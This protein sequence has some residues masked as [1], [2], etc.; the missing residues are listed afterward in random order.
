MEN[1]DLKIYNGKLITPYRVIKNGTILIRD[2]V[3]A[4]VVTGTIDYADAIEIDAGGKY[5][6]PGFVDIH[7]HGGGGYDFMDNTEDAFLKIAQTHARYGTTTMVPT[8][9]T[10]SISD[11][12]ETITCFEKADKKNVAGAQFLGMHL[13][14]PYFS[15]NQRGAQDPRYIRDPDPQEYQNILSQTNVIKR[16]SAAPELKGAIEF[17]RYIKSQGVLPSLAH[18]DAI[19]EEALL[20]FEN[21]YTLATHLYSGMSG[22]TRRNAF[23]YAGVIEAAFLI[24]DM[25]VEIIADGIHLP[26]PLLQ[27]VYK[28]KGS[29][30]IALITDAMRAAG[31][32]AT[33]SILG[34]NQNGLHVIVEDGVAK[35]PDRTAFAGSIATADRLVQTMVN[36]GI[37]LADTIQ[38]ITQ[39]P[40]RIMGTTHIGSLVAGKQADLVIFNEAIEIDTTI[41]KGK[42]VY[43]KSGNNEKHP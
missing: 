36:A 24:D 40:A 3:I 41:I 8:T 35:L 34:N 37:P 2:G 19:Y 20:G 27:L 22:V 1:A 32:S 4:D 26:A 42:I 9:L 10:S 15:M 16:W 23:R 39:T 14:G 13:E 18:T 5:I 31:T 30:H 43:S 25:D 7:V 17:A 38:M 33:E 28:I 11:L 29:S 21:G 12:L 6:A